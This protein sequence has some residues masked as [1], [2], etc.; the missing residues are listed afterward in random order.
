MV[1]VPIRKGSIAYAHPVNPNLELNQQ[2]ALYQG[3]WSLQNYWS[4]VQEDILL[5]DCLKRPSHSCRQLWRR[6]WEQV[7]STKS[8]P[9][10]FDPLQELNDVKAGI[11]KL[12]DEKGAHVP[13][14]LK[15]IDGM[16][17]ELKDSFTD[18]FLGSLSKF[19]T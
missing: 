5:F 10:S 17:A 7:K 11:I 15:F 9:R 13:C 6:S 4:K 2:L 19:D 14:V 18:H 1:P 16:L 8:S 3:Y 12:A